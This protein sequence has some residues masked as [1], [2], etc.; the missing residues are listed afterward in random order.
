M[1]LAYE[2]RRFRTHRGVDPLAMARAAWQWA[3]NGRVVSGGSTLT[4]QVARLLEPR[5]ERTLGAKLRQI[6]RAIELER[7]PRARTRCWRFI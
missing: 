6:V 1:L 5:A 3:G 7:Q 2:D 4:M